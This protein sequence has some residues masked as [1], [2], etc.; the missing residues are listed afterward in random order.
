MTRSRSDEAA[1][2]IRE[3]PDWGGAGAMGLIA[4]MIFVHLGWCLSNKRYAARHLRVERADAPALFYFY[5][6]LE[7]LVGMLAVIA[8]LS[9][10]MDWYSS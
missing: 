7:L 4:A 1:F 3:D 10:V 8:S 5:M 2:V 9:M 6:L